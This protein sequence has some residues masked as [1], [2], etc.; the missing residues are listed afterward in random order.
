[1]QLK[2]GDALNDDSALEREADTMGGRALRSAPALIAASPAPMSLP[3]PQSSVVQAYTIEKSTSKRQQLHWQSP[4]LELQPANNAVLPPTHAKLTYVQDKT[5]SGEADFRVADDYSMALQDTVNEPKDFFANDTVLRNSNAML[6]ATGSPL[7]LKKAGGQINFD[8][9]ALDKIRPKN[10]EDEDNPEFASLWSDVCIDIANTIMGNLGNWTEDV[11]LQSG[12]HM[13]SATITVN[14]ESSSGIDRLAEYLSDHGSHST[15]IDAALSA[16]TREELKQ[17]PGEGYG[18][19][20]A[21]G[22]GRAKALGVNEFAGPKVGEG[23]ATFSVRS[24]ENDRADYSTGERHLRENVWGYHHAAVVARSPDGNDWVTLE[25]YNRRLTLRNQV[26]DYLL[27]TYSDAAKKELKAENKTDAEIE[28]T[29]LNYLTSQKEDAREDYQ[30]I[31]RGYPAATMWFFRMYGSLPGQSF[32]EHRART[33][34]Y[35]NPLTVR[36]RKNVV[37]PYLNK[38]ESNELRVLNSIAPEQIS[39]APARRP[40]DI[41][42]VFTEQ[43]FADIR[44]VLNDIEVRRTESQLTR[45]LQQVKAIHTAWLNNSFVPLMADALYA[46]KR[47]TGAEPKTVNDLQVQADAEEEQGMLYDIGDWWKG[48]DASDKRLTALNNLRTAIDKV[49]RKPV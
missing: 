46:I 36:V 20:S 43:A 14:S 10:T 29:L 22:H 37:G 3:R 45:S 38:L 30:R 32:H 9:I 15:K 21:L 19:A 44:G 27:D 47:G 28:S 24:Q 49:P 23:F 18:R 7:R 31:Y 8:R 16:I 12:Q 40:L 25:N 41:L 6:E 26:Y 17:R 35:A 1:M 13:G 48:S 42:R 5:A 2:R 33:G 34:G 4:T 39:W 11:V